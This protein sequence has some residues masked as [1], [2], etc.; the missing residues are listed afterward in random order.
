MKKVSILLGLCLTLFTISCEKPGVEPDPTDPGQN[1][2]PS[3]GHVTPVGTPDG[4]AVSASMGPAG[5]TLQSADGRLSVI[6]PA[7]ALST[8]QTI[9]V[10]P[11]TNQAPGGKGPAF[12]LTPHGQSFAKP[13]TIRFQYTEKDLAGTF[14]EALGIAYQSEKG[15]WKIAGAVTHNAV[16]KTVSVETTHFS[17]WS[18]FEAISLDPAYRVIDPGQSAQLAV[19]YVVRRADD[20]DLLVPIGKEAQ[21][22]EL[23]NPEFLLDSKFIGN[24][25]LKGEGDLQATG[26]TAKYSAPN[27]IP[28]NNPIRVEVSIK[29]K[30]KA[31]G[32]LIA[33][34]YVAPEGISLQID[35]GDWETYRGWASLTGTKNVISGQKGNWGLILGWTGKT[36]GQYAWTMGTAVSFVLEDGHGFRHYQNRYGLGPDLSG[37]FLTIDDDGSETGGYVVGTFNLEPA[38]WYQT[39]PFNPTGTARIRGFFRVKGGK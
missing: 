20:S 9:Q 12:R 39:D 14:A 15:T 7:G 10:Q 19:R 33:R 8:S 21:E 38:G 28:A 1:P 3:T 17:D 27:R 30:G 2:T 32:L 6:I 11:I 29:S 23:V 34:I 13:V 36:E 35:G 31:V 4:T 37:G 16:A 25:E 26:N 22:A 24:W 18:F 5:G